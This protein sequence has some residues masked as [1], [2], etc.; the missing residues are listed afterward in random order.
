MQTI[1]IFMAL[2]GGV[3]SPKP[4]EIFYVPRDPYRQENVH[5]VV[6]SSR[7]A[8]GYSYKCLCM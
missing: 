1:L 2:K 7:N 4:M 6:F 3:S 8:S 5:R